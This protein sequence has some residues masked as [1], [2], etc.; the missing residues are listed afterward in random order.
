MKR[1]VG[2]WID[3]RQ[4]VIVILT[5]KGEETRLIKSDME[6]HV[7]FSGGSSQ[8]GRAEDMRDRQFADH[9][10]Q[11]YDDV[12]ACIRD[13]ES[14]QIF[15]PGEAKGELQKRLESKELG[16]RIVGVETVD[17]MTDRQ[18]AAKVRQHFLKK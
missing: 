7:R 18:I 12:I 1:E 5:D 4:A 11:Y 13:A 8:E 17:K 14:I 6:K 9:L 15:G 16:G 10:S 2:L 3:H